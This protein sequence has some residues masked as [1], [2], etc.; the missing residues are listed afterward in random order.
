MSDY[1][2]YGGG[3]RP[4]AQQKEQVMDQVRNQI[5][6]AV[7]QELMQVILNLNCRQF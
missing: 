3:G 4:S 7:A 6:V 5:A 1:S 2:S